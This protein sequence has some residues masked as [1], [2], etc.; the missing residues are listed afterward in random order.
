MIFFKKID[1]HES[2]LYWYV[3]IAKIENMAC[4][5]LYKIDVGKSDIFYEY[6][7]YFKMIVSLSRFVQLKLSSKESIPWELNTREI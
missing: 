6:K 4:K 2:I 3:E 7:I 5:L 1:N